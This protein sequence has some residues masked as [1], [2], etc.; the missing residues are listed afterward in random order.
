MESL[1]ILAHQDD[2][3]FALSQIEYIGVTTAIYLTDGVRSSANYNSSVREIE[4]VQ[5]WQII[6][7]GATVI[8]FGI[9]NDVSDGLLF[10]KFD[11]THF[12]KLSLILKDIKFNQIITTAPESGHQ[13]H[14]IAFAVSFMLAKK[15][16]VPL[17]I[18][19]TYSARKPGSRLFYVAD[20]KFLD[21]L[22]LNFIILPRNLKK[23]LLLL[24]LFQNYRSQLGTWIGLGPGLI[25]KYLRPQRLYLAPTNLSNASPKL[26]ENRNRANSVEV[27][28]AI[29]QILAYI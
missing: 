11:R 21:R 24:K 3:M 17:C 7:K 14:D 15:F 6:N 19:P 27:D 8:N 20:Y 13:D 5:A 12:N 9:Y 22:N 25:I 26:Y 18:F 4:S 29:K 1:I 16:N 2:E 28:A 23:L 10:K